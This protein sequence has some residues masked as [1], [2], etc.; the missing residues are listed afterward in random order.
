ME[1][2]IRFRNHISIIFEQ[3]GSVMI[4]L[5]T[6]QNHFRPEDLHPEESDPFHCFSTAD[7]LSG[8]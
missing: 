3:I 6:D 1:N 7:G 2:N 4:F 8:S 5:C